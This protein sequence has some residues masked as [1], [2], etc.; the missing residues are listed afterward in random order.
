M[1]QDFVNSSRVDTSHCHNYVSHVIHII[2]CQKVSSF[3]KFPD[4]LSGSW[5]MSILWSH[6]TDIVSLVT[7]IAKMTPL[8]QLVLAR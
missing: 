7:W 3:Q 2:V 5:R 1:T 6:E 4:T 8:L